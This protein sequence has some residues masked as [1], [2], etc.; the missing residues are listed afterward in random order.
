MQ[1]RYFRLNDAL[2]IT[3]LTNVP[4][5]EQQYFLKQ[6]F[7]LDLSSKKKNGKHLKFIPLLKLSKST[8]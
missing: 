2:M 7:F 1:I 8:M 6:K 3:E 5:I 4:K